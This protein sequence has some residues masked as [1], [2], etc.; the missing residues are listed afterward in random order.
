MP[1]L[2]T[3][4]LLERTDRGAA[5]VLRHAAGRSGPA[6]RWQ[7]ARR[8]QRAVERTP[9]G[10]ARRRSGGL[11]SLMLDGVE[12]CR[13][14]GFRRSASA[15][16]YSSRS[17]RE[18][19]R[20]LR[21]DRR[22]LAR[23]AQIL[24]HATGRH[25]AACRHVYGSNAVVDRGRAELSQSFVLENGDDVEV[26]Y[27][28][29]A[30]DPGLEIEVIVNK[31][32]RAS[33]TRSICRCRRRSSRTGNAISRP[34]ARRSASMTSNCPMPAGTT[35]PRSAG[36]A[37]PTTRTNSLSP[38]PMRRSGRSAASPSAATA[39]PTDASSATRRCSSR[40]SPTTT[41]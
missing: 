32:A 7:A 30:D 9:A 25:S 29:V 41:G 35:S 19:R 14:G 40:G 11:T 22:R 26:I 17:R 39:N 3:T 27:R 28:L 20:D 5:A 38:A 12:L 16:P 33:R 10:R 36:S 15:C 13:R 1:T 23:L 21:P 37:S 24:A 31:A 34:A 18:P 2:P 4:R 6:R 8:R